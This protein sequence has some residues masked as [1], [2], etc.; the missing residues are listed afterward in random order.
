MPGRD[1]GHGRGSFERRPA[2]TAVIQDEFK[3]TVTVSVG[4]AESDAVYV[5][6]VGR[7]QGGAP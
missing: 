5:D 1:D 4:L 3:H 6:E 2:V 7:R